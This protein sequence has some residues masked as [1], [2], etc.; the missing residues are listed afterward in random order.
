MHYLGYSSS[1]S[2]SSSSASD[3][4]SPSAFNRSC[5]ETQHSLVAHSLPRRS[6][7]HEKRT[8]YL[9]FFSSKSPNTIS[10]SSSSLCA[11]FLSSSVFLTSASLCQ[12]VSKLS[13]MKNTGRDDKKAR[14]APTF[15]NSFSL[16]VSN[17][18]TSPTRFSFSLIFFSS[19]PT[20]V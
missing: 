9:V 17:P 20:L 16:V 5:K 13:G 12:S 2:S 11:D 4:A 1:S 19:S 15:V 6:I 14:A 18:S 10:K 8:L 3:M 7:N